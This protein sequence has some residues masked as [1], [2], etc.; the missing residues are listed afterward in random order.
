MK[1][2]VFGMGYVGMVLSACLGK[3][4]HQIIGVDIDKDKINKLTSGQSPIFE[5][6]LPELISQG[7]KNKNLRFTSDS[8][9]AIDFAEIIYITVG[10][11]S[12]SDGSV[13]L[14]YIEEVA[15]T[16]S[17]NL[18]EHK[19]I[20]IKSTVPA[21]TA[22]KVE[23]IIKKEYHGQFD[24]ISNP[25]F[26]REGSAVL[27][28]LKPDRIVIGTKDKKG[29]AAQKIEEL[30]NF[31][32]CT[33]LITDNASAEMIKYAAN[34]F[35]AN[36]ISYINMVS[37]ICEKFNA[38]VETVSLGMKLDKRIGL[39]AYL[40]AGIGYGGSCFTK[41]VQAF[42]ATAKQTDAEHSLLDDIEI[43]FCF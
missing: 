11:P 20:A 28:F 35:L 24:I 18:K 37:N 29:K 41:D 31:C 42:L 10:T 22:K 15:K 4:K 12:K 16:I 7:V 36:Q 23:E 9:K 25:E 34:A 5:P 30:F 21:G 26:L 39:R 1:I 13:D 38:D 8:K 33:I 32:K 40:G 17:Q 14:K 2:A 43:L 27:D 19:I 3:F 6:R